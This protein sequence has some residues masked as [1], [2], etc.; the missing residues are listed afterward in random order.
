MPIHQPVLFVGRQMQRSR[1]VTAG[2]DRIE[3][4]DAVAAWFKAA[5]VHPAIALDVDRPA[6]RARGGQQARRGDAG[7]IDNPAVVIERHKIAGHDVRFIA[8][9]GSDDHADIRLADGRIRL[10]R[11]RGGGLVS[12]L[13]AHRG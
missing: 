10:V 7:V 9:A 13:A 6:A 3:R 4:D 5:A 2:D 8:P 1:Q 12:A 11:R